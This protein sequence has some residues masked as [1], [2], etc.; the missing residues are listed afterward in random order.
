[1]S[2][3]G[4][5]SFRPGTLRPQPQQ[6][7]VEQKLRDV[8]QA[9]EKMFLREMV[10]A[11]RSTV[12]ESGLIKQNPMEKL[13]R[14]ELDSEYVGSWGSKGGVGLADLIHQNLMDR[15]G[16]RLG[17]KEVVMKPSG[18]L[19]MDSRSETT[20]VAR[21]PS[22]R[23][24]ETLLRFDGLRGRG[25]EVVAPWRGVLLGSKRLAD[26]LQMAEIRH[27]NGLVGTLTWK[28]SGGKL[29]A[30]RVVEPGERLGLLSMDA[31][32]LFWGLR[33]Q[34]EGSPSVPE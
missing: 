33:E 27:D 8:S 18:P 22:P 19:R 20:T 14:E 9:Y 17:L 1:M 34:D 10:K 31:Q 11:M 2:E 3:T 25:D 6:A 29:E 21:M 23:S 12:G 4:G 5:S 7:S 13:F 24:G 28:G 26:D 16:E 32:S 15:F 30:G